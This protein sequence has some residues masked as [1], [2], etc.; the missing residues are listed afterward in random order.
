MVKVEANIF[1]IFLLVGA[2]FFANHLQKIAS[3]HIKRNE[4]TM[5]FK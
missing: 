1:N 2:G 5:G 3:L 4:A